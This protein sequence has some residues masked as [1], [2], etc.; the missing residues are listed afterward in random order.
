[1]NAEIVKAFLEAA[2]AN[3]EFVTN[4]ADAV[5]RV[6]SGI[7]YDAV[8]MD[9]QMPEMDGLEAT[10]RIR[11]LGVAKLPIIAM[12]AHAMDEER[13]RCLDAG[14]ND[15]VAKPF[16]PATLIAALRRWVPRVAA[17]P[18]PTS[19]APAAGTL[20][21]SLPPFDLAAALDRL[22]GNESLLG[23]IIAR[24]AEEFAQADDTLAER[25]SGQRYRDAERLAHSLAGV[26]A[27]LSLNELSAAAKA[28]ELALREGSLN[29]V[30]ALR[31]NVATTLTAALAAA[32]TLQS[33]TDHPKGVPVA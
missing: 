9:V 21:R 3:A 33:P 7:A 1:V 24:F 25:I 4:G 29:E 26:A 32:A 16:D 15:H 14:M 18:A 8:L 27:Q 11:E 2:G 17:A 31:A 12:T 10:R 20:P 28:L 23:R 5:E 30:E 13:Q 19:A 22:D 6:A